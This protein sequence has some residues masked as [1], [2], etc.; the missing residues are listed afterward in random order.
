MMRFVESLVLDVYTWDLGNNNCILRTGHKANV[1]P[2]FMVDGH[3]RF[4]LV[5]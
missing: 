2:F 4:Y 1:K 5:T 3:I